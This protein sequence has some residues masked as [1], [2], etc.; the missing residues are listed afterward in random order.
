M[1]DLW[2]RGGKTADGRQIW[3]P[4]ASMGEKFNKG[5]GYV[6]KQYAPFSIPQF[7]RL[8]Q[9]VTGTPGP[10][11]EKYNVSDEIGGFY[12][13][14]GISMPPTEVLKKMDFKINEFKSGIRNTRGLF[15]GEVLKG[16]EISHDDIINRYI[17]ANAQRYAVM[18]K[19]KQVNDAAVLLEVSPQ[20]LRKKFM[21]RGEANAY[22]HISTDRF[23][24]FEITDPIAKKFREQR[25]ALESEFDDL[26]FEA[27]YSSGTIQTLN[28]LKSLMKQI[29]LG[30]NFY[31]YV[32]P[33]DWLIDTK[34]SEAP[35]GEQQA[36]RTPLPPTPMPDQQVVQTTPQ[37]NQGVLPNGLTRSETAL[38][39]PEE[40]L[41]K[42]NQ[43]QAGQQT[44]QA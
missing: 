7:E 10:R 9:A 41:I 22:N 4:D 39:R 14:R 21:D 2:A 8:E 15:S 17:E 31:D 3:N 27:P 5:L 18:N 34:R 32:K 20:D 36:A 38:L 44:G 6:A 25:T 24:P 16:G 12:G 42:L 33:E 35:G 11:G 28:Q 29:P 19:M 30:S 1:F 13:L 23:Y 40:Q 37:V 43:R 26:K